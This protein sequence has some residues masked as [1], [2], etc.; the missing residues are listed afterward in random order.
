MRRINYT[1]WALL[2]AAI[3][4]VVSA[5]TRSEDKSGKEFYALLDS[6]SKYRISGKIDS[7]IMFVDAASSFATT[8]FQKECVRERKARMLYCIGDREKSRTLLRDVLQ[9]FDRHQYLKDNERSLKLNSLDLLATIEEENGNVKEALRLYQRSAMI[10][11][12]LGEQEMYINAQLYV[13]GREYKLGRFTEA[14]EELQSLLEFCNEESIEGIIKFRIIEGLYKAYLAL[15]DMESARHYI[16]EMESLMIPGNVEERCLYNVSLYYLS[17]SIKNTALQRQC[18]EELDKCVGSDKLTLAEK[19][20]ALQALALHRIKSGE[21]EEAG[22]RLKDLYDA[23]KIIPKESRSLKSE[24]MMVRYLIASSQL[25]S[26]RSILSTIDEQLYKEKDMMQYLTYLA[27]KSWFAYA[28]KDYKLSYAILKNRALLQDSLKQES[29]SHNLAYKTLRHKRDATI[30]SQQLKIQHQLSEIEDMSIR[31]QIVIAFAIVVILLVVLSFVIFRSVRVKR[32]SAQVKLANMKLEREVKQQTEVLEK[33]EIELRRKNKQLHEQMQYASN[34]QF[35]MLPDAE[36]ISSV[37]FSQVFV[38]YRPCALISGD[39][40]WTS[41]IGSKKCIC[42]GDATGHGIPGAFIAMVSSTI[43]N[44][45]ALTMENPSPL[46]LMTELDNNIRS[47][48]LSNDTSHGNDSVDASMICID[49]KENKITLAL[50]RHNAY[51]VNV[52]GDVKRIAGVKRSIGD[53]DPEF[54]KR[55][56]EEIE[57]HLSSGDCLYLMSDGYESQLGGP[58]YKKFKR[59]RMEALLSKYRE[60]RMSDQRLC[61][62]KDLEEWMAD[63]EQTDDI[64]MVGMRIA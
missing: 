60:Y 3:V 29:I 38:I 9:Y 25:D 28:S 5:C 50:A 41:Q 12:E 64:L 37:A 61:L 34:I 6:A 1:Y 40:Y 23:E 20:E 32:H 44:D 21:Y 22:V 11:K 62:L 31:R 8:E 10:A 49:E 16:S 7:A 52:N 4:V 53:I 63:N 18:I 19:I 59:N 57:L 56:F 33:R 55:P 45:L 43:L 35:S 15:G 27:Y 39:F 42:V 17:D 26:A 46:A 58:N 51:V 36:T 14:I 47:I 2:F 24:M 13:S 30:M 54:M 48:F